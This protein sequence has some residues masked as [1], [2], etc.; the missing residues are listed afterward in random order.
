MSPRSGLSERQTEAPSPLLLLMLKEAFSF[1]AGSEEGG[2]REAEETNGKR[3]ADSKKSDREMLWGE[4]VRASGEGGVAEGGGHRGR[5]SPPHH[6]ALNTYYGHG[7]H[8]A[9]C[10]E[11]EESD[12]GLRAAAPFCPKSGPTLRKLWGQKKVTDD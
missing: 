11:R 6:P 10:E 12:S 8:G 1:S 2:T 5:S 9:S 4:E 3:A 7:E